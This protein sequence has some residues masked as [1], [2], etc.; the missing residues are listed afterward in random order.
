M[1]MSVP[2]AKRISDRKIDSSKEED[3]HEKQ[4][5]RAS[6]KSSTLSAKTTALNGVKLKL[7]NE[8][9][10]TME[11]WIIS[12]L[13]FKFTIQTLDSSIPA[14]TVVQ[15][16][17]HYVVIKLFYGPRTIDRRSIRWYLDHFLDHLYI[18]LVY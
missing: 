7:E 14:K 3:S 12:T 4:V 10:K 9:N 2:K 5:K 13:N 17:D 6:Q 15:S 8:K 11:R 16:A 18:F 1:K